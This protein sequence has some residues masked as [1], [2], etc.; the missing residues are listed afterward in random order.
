VANEGVN[1][2]SVP[3]TRDRQA[4]EP[5]R[6]GR[7]GRRRVLLVDDDPVVR[8]VLATQLADE[9]YEVDEAG[10]GTAALALLDRSGP[11]HMLVSDLA[12][13]G[14]DGVAL[15]RE[16]Q[17][18]RPGLP[19]ILLTGY[20]GDAARLAVGEAVGGA[21]TLLRKPVTGAQLADHVAAVLDASQDAPATA[22]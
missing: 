1:R 13:P 7:R 15:I 19:A 10:D 12:M 3:D 22:G 17:R 21:F 20:A 2:A 4:L 6:P 14:M 5:V 9:G 16:A 11:M 8:D 18:R